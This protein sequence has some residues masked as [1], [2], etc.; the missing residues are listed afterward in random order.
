MALKAEIPVQIPVLPIH[1]ILSQKKME[2]EQIKQ[3][4]QL[5]ENIIP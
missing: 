5:P 4:S 1:P 2:Q 3:L